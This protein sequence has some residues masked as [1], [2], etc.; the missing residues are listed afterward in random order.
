MNEHSRWFWRMD[1]WQR[2]NTASP[3][4]LYWNHITRL[5]KQERTNGKDPKEAARVGQV[6]RSGAQADQG[7]QVRSHR[8]EET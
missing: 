4:N 5:L 3:G 6:R 2:H 8:T 7:S 1:G